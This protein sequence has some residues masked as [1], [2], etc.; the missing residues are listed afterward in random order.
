M[1]PALRP[2]TRAV[3]NGAGFCEWLAELVAYRTAE[4]EVVGSKPE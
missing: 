3:V 4:R 1:V 2:K